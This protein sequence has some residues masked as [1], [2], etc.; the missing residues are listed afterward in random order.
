MVVNIPHVDISTRT[1]TVASLLNSDQ[2]MGCVIECHK[3]K[4][5][6][7][8]LIR[9]PGQ[10]KEEFG[11]EMDAYWAAGG[12]PFYAVRAAYGSVA[13]ATEY[14]RDA[15]IQTADATPE[16]GKV[17]KFEAA[18]PGKNTLYITFK[19]SGSGVG[20]RLSV[21]IEEEDG[22]TEYFLG[23]RRSLVANQ[24]GTYK[25]ALENL[26]DKINAESSL[27]KAYFKAVPIADVASVTYPVSAEWAQET[28]STQGVYVGS[29]TYTALGRQVLGATGTLGSDGDQTKQEADQSEFDII[30]DTVLTEGPDAGS[31]PSEVA[32]AAALKT[33]E[34]LDITGIFSLKSNP[35]AS[36]LD[37]EQVANTGDIYAPYVEHVEKMNTSEQHGWRFVILG[38][39]EKMNLLARLGQAATFN[40]EVIIF[41]GGGIVDTNGKIY[42]PDTA[43]QA[44]AGKIS[45]TKYNISIWGGKPS[46][47]LMTDRKFITDVTE[48]PGEPIYADP[49]ANPLVMTGENAATRT[50][51][52][53]YNE[54]G[55]LTFIKDDDG[56]KITEGVTTAQNYYSD[57]GVRKEDEIAVMRVIIHTEYAVYEACYRMLGQTLTNTF[58]MDL[59]NSVITKLAEIASEG[60]IKNYNCVAT[61]GA[62]NAS[63]E[64]GTIQVDI[65]ITPIHTARI[66][67][68]TITVL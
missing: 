34:E 23:I 20:Q 33:L 3:G 41:V 9:S 58:Q 29:S 10:L 59:E 31:S 50:E 55:V 66:I 43:T 11:V 36:R 52:I 39:N 13:A 22:I 27:V 28:T 2:T 12:G 60:A 64:Q 53:A 6:V 47:A 68:A 7:P 5:N 46:K 16:A 48:L 67:D 14:V 1:G 17:I 38:A 57:Y 56:V 4:A 32:H 61:I 21:T 25:S 18:K 51:R 15:T 54:G 30:S 40:S 8:V 65:S 26:V 62:E 19:S 35:F 37:S 45:A 42:E 63:G 44:V 24:A 49:T